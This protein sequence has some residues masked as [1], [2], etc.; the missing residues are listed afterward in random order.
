MSI[1]KVIRYYRKN[2]K[3]TQKQLGGIFHSDS[4]VSDIERGIVFPSHQTL[5]DFS[6]ILGVNLT[7]YLEY[8]EA[9]DPLKVE[10]IVAEA[11]ELTKN[12]KYTEANNLI[13][14]YKNEDNYFQTSNGKLIVAKYE[15]IYY[16]RE[17]KLYDKA[18]DILKIA[19]VENKK[20]MLGYLEIDIINNIGIMYTMNGAYKEA[21]KSFEDAHKALEGLTIVED[22]RLN[23]SVLYNL[24]RINMDLENYENVK[25]YSER[26]ISYCVENEYTYM[27]AKAYYNKGIAEFAL[28]DKASATSSF[29]LSYYLFLGLQQLENANRMLDYVKEHCGIDLISQ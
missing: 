29:K 2:S 14:G 24:S 25:D 15:A 18:T 9:E 10:S 8:V 1:G 13:Q 5:I 19:L 12:Y 16:S 17:K 3:L 4:H 27:L 20:K 22:K 21:L 11:V 7:N 26:L 28:M 23:S 6:N